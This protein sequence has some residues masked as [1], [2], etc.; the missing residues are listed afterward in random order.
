MAINEH[1]TEFAGKPVRDWDPAQP[2]DPA[3]VYRVGV[4]QDEEDAGGRWH[5]KFARF[6]ASPGVDRL[7]GLIVGSWGSAGQ[8]ESSAPVVEALVAARAQ[9]PALRALFFG[10][11]ISEENEISWII[12]SDVT[13]L[14]D[15][16]PALE[17]LRVRGGHGLVLG[18]LRH[19]RLRSL[20]IEAGGLDAGVV[21]AV[22]AADLP[23]LEHLELWLGTSEY[24]GTV[25]VADL[26]PIL[27]GRLFPRLRYLGLRDS[28]IADEVAAAV[29]S[30]PVLERVRV[31]DLSLG[32]LGDAGAAALIA[33]PA[34]RRL[35]RLDLH[36]HYCSDET[37]ARL[38]ALGV[39]IDLDD[40]EEEDEFRGERWRY[41]AVSE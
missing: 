1:A 22:A 17:E 36:H 32:T 18:A 29:A 13:P 39:E 20:A 33:S 19:A 24:G 37:M 6:L 15:A 38:A 5:D 12:Q 34:V 7:S 28:E 3:V 10:D 40:R 11:I 8:E 14:L 4:T 35:E 27:S 2:L 31:L 26:E 41:V 9:M 23:A 16:F 30:A 21:R 25:T